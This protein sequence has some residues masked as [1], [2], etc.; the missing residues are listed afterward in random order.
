MFKS[1]LMNELYYTQFMSSSC[2]K[3]ESKISIKEKHKKK[4]ESKTKK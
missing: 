3:E 1:D 4:G 2:F